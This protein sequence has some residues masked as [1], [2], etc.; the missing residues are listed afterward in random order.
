MEISLA[1][2]VR[3]MMTNNRQREIWCCC[4]IQ[5]VILEKKKQKKNKTD[6]VAKQQI[7][8]LKCLHAYIVLCV[9]FLLILI[10][11]STTG[12]LSLSIIKNKNVL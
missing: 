5:L 9:Y 10:I 1:R 7:R 6:K 4:L 8:I 3:L 2:C 12:H 11:T